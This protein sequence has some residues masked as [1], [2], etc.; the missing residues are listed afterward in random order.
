MVSKLRTFSISFEGI[1]DKAY[2]NEENFCRLFCG[3]LY[4]AIYYKEVT[5]VSEEIETVCKQISEDK[6]RS[7]DFR[8]MSNFITKMCQ[9]IERQVVLIIDEVDQ[10]SDQ[11]IFLD[12]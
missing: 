9:E 12:F 3:L 8:E 4:D 6:N 11:K 1:G 10:A 5:G 2:L 7:V